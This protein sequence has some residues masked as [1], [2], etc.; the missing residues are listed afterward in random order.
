MKT[1]LL[2]LVLCFAMFAAMPI[3]L[4]AEDVVISFDYERQRGMAS[5]QFAVWI[6]DAKG[7]L[8]KPIFVTR[9]TGNGGWEHR[10]DSLPDWTSSIGQEESVDAMAGSTP[11]SGNIEYLWDCTDTDGN[12]VPDGT[13]VFCVEAS[14]RWKNRAVFKGTIKL[15]G[16]S[17]TV[18]ASPKYYGEDT[19]DRVMI[20]NVSAALVE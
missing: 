19:A 15:D 13:Y 1:K 10:A 3:A 11:K 12:P 7:H 4:F 6:E 16:E 2:T 14:L 5:N 17:F 9:F 8:V 18:D 20:Q